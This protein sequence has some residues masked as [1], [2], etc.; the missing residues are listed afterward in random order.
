VVLRV[1]PWIQLK[2]LPKNV[3]GMS[4]TQTPQPCRLS[5]G[6]GGYSVNLICERWCRV[7]SQ[8]ILEIFVLKKRPGNRVF[9]KTR[10]RTWQGH[11]RVL[12]Q[13]Q[14]IS[15]N[16]FLGSQCPRYAHTL[17]HPPPSCSPSSGLWWLLL[18]EILSGMF[19]H[20]CQCQTLTD[21]FVFSL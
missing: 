17:C 10:T 19:G 6:P 2:F 8:E 4:Q 11:L 18:V 5:N 14:H 12:A 20:H 7:V 21:P 15:R 16:L 3:E 1:L 13:K 9:G